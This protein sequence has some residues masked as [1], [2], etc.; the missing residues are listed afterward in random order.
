MKKATRKNRI[1][2]FHYGKMV[3]VASAFAAFITACGGGG[4]NS[5]VAKD[6]PNETTNTK[7]QTVKPEEVP[8]KL[9]E[10]KYAEVYDQFS[11]EFKQQLSEADFVKMAPDSLKGVDS[12]KQ[13]SVMKLNGSEQRSW[14]SDSGKIGLIT[15]F[16]EKGTILGLQAKK[17]SPSPETDNRLT[18]IKYDWPLKGEWFV[19]WGGTNALVNY[20]YEYESQ[21]YA[22]DLIQKK[23]G[24]SYKGD[25]LKN[26]S[27]YAFGQPILAPTSGTVVSVVNNIPDNE[28][29]G[30]MNEKVPAGNEVVIDHGG[31]YSVLAHMKKGS[32]KVKVG[33]KVKSG[34]EI[35]LLGNS[36]NSSEAHLH[37]QVSDGADLFKSRSININWKNRIAPVQGETI[38]A[39]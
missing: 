20:H 15:V 34:D 33:D 8:E 27:Y 32:V 5:E 14:I 35:G 24:Y 4:G 9:L 26:T 12:F 22:Y 1:E 30:V 36:G 21:R 17:L 23:D 18:K 3:L 16:D 11:N 2:I 29:V 39:E 13:A 7:D 25:P 31:E 28:P 10:G 19:T 37:F 38:T 6:I